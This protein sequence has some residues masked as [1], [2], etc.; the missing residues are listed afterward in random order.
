VL[1]IAAEERV[2]LEY[3]INIPKA[4]SMGRNFGAEGKR[5]RSCVCKEVESRDLQYLWR[6]A[7]V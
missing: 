4:Q 1:V 7:V 3:E 5:A 6:R 2:E